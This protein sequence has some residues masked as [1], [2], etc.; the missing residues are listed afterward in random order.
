MKERKDRRS[1]EERLE[2]AAASAKKTEEALKKK[3]DKMKDLQN[4]IKAKRLEMISDKFESSF[5]DVNLAGMTEDEF[6]KFL[7][8]IRFVNDNPDVNDD[9][10][11]NTEE[12]EEPQENPDDPN[13]QK[14]IQRNPVNP[15]NG[16]ENQNMQNGYRMF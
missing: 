15:V 10:Q 12:T 11:E 13:L 7:Q 2:S 1:L 16:Q 6:R 9:I 4:Q 14:P 8:N 5:P 3:R